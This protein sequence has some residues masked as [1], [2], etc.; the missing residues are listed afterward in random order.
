MKCQCGK[1]V[2]TSKEKCLNCLI[3][4]MRK[5]EIENHKEQ[6]KLDA[7]DANRRI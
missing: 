4:D 7:L 5:K 1:E 3:K 6:I 2:N